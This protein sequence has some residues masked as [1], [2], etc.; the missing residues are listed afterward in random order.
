MLQGIEFLLFIRLR[1][2]PGVVAGPGITIP[3]GTHT[4]I[5]LNTWHGTMNISEERQRCNAA[6]RFYKR[7]IAKAKLERVPRIDERLKDYP[8]ESRAFWSLAKAA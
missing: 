5:G 6:S 7:A 3:I 2:P 4:S 8:S 1:Y